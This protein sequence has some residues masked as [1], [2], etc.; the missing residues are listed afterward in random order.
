MTEKQGKEKPELEI[1]AEA[2]NK[3]NLYR[4]MREKHGLE[5][6]LEESEQELQQMIA[7]A[8]ADSEIFESTSFWGK[9]DDWSQ[10][11]Q[12][13]INTTEHELPNK[14]PESF[15]AHWLLKLREYKKELRTGIVETE[16]VQQRKQEAIDK[17]NRHGLIALVGET[18]TGKTKLAVKMANELT[19]CY[20]FVMGHEK[21]TKE[22]ML[23]YLGIEPQ[24]IK[25]ED[26][27]KLI[28]QAQER[29]KELNPDLLDEQKKEKFQW[30][31][32]VI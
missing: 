5:K 19:G 9:V 17:L 25:A 8:K 14:N 15:M 3:K 11:N 27:P 32:Q 28:E 21:I 30:I 2:F 23:Y 16:T 29:Y 7:K 1:I 6:V 13:I 22:D 26:A 20:E 10:F 4:F 24:T 18:G 31:E 12:N